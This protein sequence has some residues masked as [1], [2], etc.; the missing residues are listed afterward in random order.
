MIRTLSG[1]AAAG[2]LLVA[3]LQA[4]DDAPRRGGPG[5]SLVPY[6]GWQ[7]ALGTLLSDSDPVGGWRAK[8]G[9]VLGVRLEF[10]LNSR[11]GI[12]V[13][14]AYTSAQIEGFGS[15]YSDFE[16]DGRFL[17][18]TGRISRLLSGPPTLRSRRVG[19]S[20][21]AGGGLMRHW[22]AS[23]RPQFDNWPTAVGGMTIRLPIARGLM[24]YLTG[25]V[26]FYNASFGGETPTSAL[27]KDLR[28]TLGAW[29]P[30][31]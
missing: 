18:L 19:V 10:P 4:Q 12:Q 26:Y 21:H 7:H 25:E 2:L 16:G 17:S 24:T 8:D 30:G 23:P 15:G 3:P 28:V 11:T 29:L 20:V 22:V 5:P 14:G 31:N 27:Q 13:D 1:L 6:V 9:L